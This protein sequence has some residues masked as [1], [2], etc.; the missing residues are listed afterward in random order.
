MPVVQDVRWQ[1]PFASSPTSLQKLG[2]NISTIG[3]RL[4]MTHRR[5]R[6]VNVQ[7]RD[8]T[9]WTPKDYAEKEL[10]LAM[11]VIGADE[12]TGVPASDPESEMWA[13]L[14]NLRRLFVTDSK[15]G[16][17]TY[18][19]PVQNKDIVA[20]CEVRSQIDFQTM[21]G[22]TRAA[23]IVT[24]HTPGVWFR[25]PGFVAETVFTSRANAEQWTVNIDSDVLIKDPVI[26]LKAAT[27]TPSNVQIFNE[28]LS[29]ADNWVKYT[30]VFVTGEEVEIDVGAWRATL[31]GATRV[32]GNV[33]WSGNPQ[34]FWLKPGQNDLKIEVTGGPIDVKI[35]AKGAYW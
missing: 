22:A 21:A 26:W 28:S 25:D 20:E 2:F 4:D 34:F 31:D 27:G 17:L 1:P 29:A 33:Q 8:G 11:W 30:D 23:F 10:E 3:G 35:A 24:M 16:F 7:Y 32:T 14:E 18:R 15:L 12:D 13:N 9:L 6:N 19:H 5:G